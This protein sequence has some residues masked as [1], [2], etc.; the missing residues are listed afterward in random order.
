MKKYKVVIKEV[1]ITDYEIEAEN[2]GEAREK[3]YSIGL[4][5]G[6]KDEPII[7]NQETIESEIKDIREI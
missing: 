2:V 6:K 5:F 3:S 7:L 4:L 1:I